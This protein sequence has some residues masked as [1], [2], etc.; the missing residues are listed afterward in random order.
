MAK[1]GRRPVIAWR[2]SSVDSRIASVRYRCLSFSQELEKLGYRNEFSCGEHPVDF[3]QDIQS[4]IFVKT[5]SDSDLATARCARDLGIPVYIDLCDNIFFWPGYHESLGDHEKAAKAQRVVE[6]FRRIMEYA[7]GVITTGDYLAGVIRGAVQREVP[8]YILEDAIN[9]VQM[10]KSEFKRLYYRRFLFGHGLFWFLN[11]STP[12]VLNALGMKI[13][14]LI[15]QGFQNAIKVSQKAARFYARTA[16]NSRFYRW[17][18]EVHQVQTGTESVG[19]PAALQSDA[20]CIP[21]GEIQTAVNEPLKRV[22]WFGNS[23]IPGVYGISD[24]L[25]LKEDLRK[26]FAEIKFKLTVVTNSR[27]AFC[28]VAPQLG[29]PCE[30]VKWSEESCAEAIGM[31]DAVII[32][33]AENEFSMSKSSNRTLMALSFGRPVVASWTPALDSLKGFIFIGDFAANLVKALKAGTQT[34]KPDEEMI[35]NLRQT[36]SREKIVRKLVGLISKEQSE[37]ISRQA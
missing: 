33:C 1:V 32:P 18:R 24:L 2:L 34:Q 36:Y 19:L 17:T 14:S 13:S 30:F 25:S 4:L 10:S 5:F 7:S 15:H 20:E 31:S 28:Q 23:G 29:V 11:F 21:N 35:Q 6:N 3:D 27:D 37:S 8:V 9:P 26:A 12:F 16:G 22:V